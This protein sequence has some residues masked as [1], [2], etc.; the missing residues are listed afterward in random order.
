[1]TTLVSEVWPP[2]DLEQVPACPVCGSQER[3]V[4]HAD[5]R[6]LQFLCAPGLWTFH[7]CLQCSSAYLDPRP[8]R[9]SIGR[10]YT[11]YYTHGRPCNRLGPLGKVQRRL[12]Y[13]FLNQAHGYR[14]YP[15][16]RAGAW[17]LRVLPNE[18]SLA[19]REIRHLTRRGN[20]MRVLDVGCGSGAFLDLMRW[21]GWSG[22]GLEP[23]QSAVDT[24]RERGLEVIQ[25]TVDRLAELPASSFD[26]I[27]MS[28]AIEHLHDPV[29]SL[30]A[31]ARL[32]APD[33]VMYIATP[34]LDA[35]GHSVFGADWIGLDPPRHL[36]LFTR[37]S[38]EAA[39]RAAGLTVAGAARG[40][41]DER[42]IYL[43]SHRVRDRYRG[44]SGNVH[45]GLQLR[46]RATNWW[47]W[48]RPRRASE[49]AIMC[50]IWDRDA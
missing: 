32:L 40:S 14:L 34:N 17:L 28:H 35:R 19:L 37:D 22:V 45:A 16:W 18:R 25:G 4:L 48:V 9:G 26:A 27:T 42:R 11:V 6:D 49:I 38:L 15:A 44:G 50:R 43:N 7:R 21:Q 46:A 20:G 39:A 24:A 30:R 1:M 41:W 33:G 29:A 36:V 10:A 47:G 3:S 23:D 12:R 13:G 2:G 31:C 8:T 5:L